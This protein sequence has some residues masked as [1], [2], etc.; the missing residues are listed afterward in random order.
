MKYTVVVLLLIVSMP[1]FCQ[2]KMSAEPFKGANVI[3]IR[4]DSTKSKD[5]LFKLVGETLVDAGYTLDVS[6]REFYQF[7]IGEYVM[8]KGYKLIYHFSAT[9]KASDIILRVTVHQDWRSGGDV[10]WTW[11]KAGITVFRAIHDD[12]VNK[13]KPLGKIGYAEM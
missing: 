13:V 12:I 7:K 6:N 1:V 11:V 3:V 9:I 10:P 8:P 2:Q 5:A 4:A